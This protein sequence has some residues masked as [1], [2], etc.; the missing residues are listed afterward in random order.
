MSRRTARLCVIHH[1]HQKQFDG[2]FRWPMNEVGRILEKQVS[3]LVYWHCPIVAVSPSTRE[4][5]RRSLGFRN[6]VYLVPNGAPGAS[7]TRVRHDASP[8]IAVVSRLVPHKRVDLLIGA[9][10]AVLAGWPDLHVDIVGDGSE[11]ENLTKLAAQLGL[12][13]GVEFHGW[14]DEQR[15]RY[16]LARASLT[17]VPSAAEG[18]GLT[19]IEANSVGT[20]ALGYDVPG[21]RDAIQHGRTGWLL[22]VGTDL[23]DGIAD[24]LNELS[25]DGAPER[26]ARECVRWAASFSWDESAARFA[27]VI[28]A[29]LDLRRWN[30]RYI[31]RREVSDIAVMVQLDVRSASQV[32]RLLRTSIRRTDM[33][34]RR[35]NFFGLL[36]NSCDEVQA[37]SVLDRLGLAGEPVTVTVA[38]RKEL[39]VG[40]DRRPA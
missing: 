8:V 37:F 14:V 4:E 10:P 21:L 29:D 18:W 9:L 15:K 13:T 27:R 25:D 30:R 2:R 40:P 1:V 32:E 39:I 5:V 36:L 22:P 26:L 20:P 24:A 12:G 31:S 38:R 23:A 7:E 35:Q 16:V 34:V 11:F 33:W 28:G 17:V 19:V 6:P 3:R